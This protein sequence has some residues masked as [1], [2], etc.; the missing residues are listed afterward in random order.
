VSERI[1]ECGWDKLCRSAGLSKAQRSQLEDVIIAHEDVKRGQH[2]FYEGEPL[3]S[4]FVVR[5]GCIKAWVQANGSHEQIVRFYLPGEVLGLNAIG[6][7]Q[8]RSTATALGKAS[9]LE[10]P[11]E[12]LQSIVDSAPD[13]N[14]RIYRMLSEEIG[15]DEQMLSLLMNRSAEERLAGFLLDLSRRHG[16]DEAP[17]TEFRLEM[18]RH[19]IANYLGLAR[20]TVSVTI[21]RFHNVGLLKVKGRSIGVLDL[22]RLEELGS[23]R[24][25]AAVA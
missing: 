24:N 12:A 25:R 1:Q 16:G 21:T 5:R 2:L 9:I 22:Q 3:L 7:R 13:L 18:P 4:L 17:A 14:H 23:L 20:E 19:D 15:S 8:H 10:L 6:R 11:F